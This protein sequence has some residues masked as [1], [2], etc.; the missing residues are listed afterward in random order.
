MSDMLSLF[1]QAQIM[2]EK[3]AVFQEEMERQYFTGSAGDGAV[4]VTLNG[5]HEMQKI[6]IDSKSVQP[7]DIEKL[8]NWI[9]AAVNEAGLQVNV[10]LKE[11]VAKMTGGL[12]LPGLF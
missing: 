7:A 9:Q 4:T 11:E 1:R 12:G 10:R 6:V 3:M 5:K 2:K 8:Q